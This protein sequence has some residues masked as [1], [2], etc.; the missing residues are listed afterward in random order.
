L[1]RGCF[2]PPLGFCIL[3]Y[4]VIISGYVFNDSLEVYNLLPLAVWLNASLL[5]SVNRWPLNIE[6]VEM[7]FYDIRLLASFFFFF[8]LKKKSNKFD[9][10]IRFD[11]M[12]KNFWSWSVL[13]VSFMYWVDAWI[14]TAWSSLW[15]KANV[16]FY[17]I[18]WFLLFFLLAIS[19][20][21]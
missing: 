3:W 12:M 11:L 8:F 1:C 9:D 13:F 17:S 16:V 6:L 18:A 10:Y 14:G 2:L 7:N 20:N 15:L 4:P 21:V 19:I 5:K